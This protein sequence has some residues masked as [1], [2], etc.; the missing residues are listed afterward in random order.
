LADFT[1]FHFYLLPFP[2]SPGTVNAL[3]L[4]AVARRGLPASLAILFLILCSLNSGRFA[5]AGRRPACAG[6]IK[7]RPER[8]PSISPSVKSLTLSDFPRA[9]F[10]AFYPSCEAVLIEQIEHAAPVITECHWTK[11]R[12]VK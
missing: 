9:V 4:S 11:S 8:R 7:M 10:Q 12:S 2:F 5:L 1:G 6:G 3:L